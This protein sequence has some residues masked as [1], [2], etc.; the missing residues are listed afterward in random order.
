MSRRY[1][2]SSIDRHHED[3]NDYYDRHEDDAYQD[4][5]LFR[6]EA[7]VFSH[8]THRAGGALF[9]HTHN[10]TF[11]HGRHQPT[12]LQRSNLR[13][14]QSSPNRYNLPQFRTNYHTYAE[15]T[16]RDYRVTHTTRTNSSDAPRL[17]A[18]DAK[19]QQLVRNLSQMIKLQH[20]LEN[21]SPVT[22]KQGP[23]MISRTVDLLCTLIKPAAP[24]PNTTDFLRG[25]ARQWGV[26]TLQILKQHYEDSLACVLAD[27]LFDLPEDWKHL[28]QVA[29]RWAKRRLRRLRQCTVDTT[30]Q[31]IRQHL[32]VR[33]N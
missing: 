3:Y 17:P 18:P 13:R 4:R 9:E 28:Y 32:L 2:D 30:E 23:R 12:L 31:L 10:R 27:T 6:E 24:T 33:K 14:Q 5:H 11:N 16:A 26:V 22:D 1:R 19:F 20:H 7:P 29:T 8:G 25:N 21:V 15:V